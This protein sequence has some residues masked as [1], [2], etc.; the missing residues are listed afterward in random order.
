MN[1]FE[2][3]DRALRISLA[4][5]PDLAESLGRLADLRWRQGDVAGT[6][7]ALDQTHVSA[8]N[9]HHV[10]RLRARFFGQTGKLD[11]ALAN[12]DRVIALADPHWDD[13][14]TRGDFLIAH[15]RLDAADA[16]YARAGVLNPSAA[17]V[18]LHRAD[19][20]ARGARFD[21]ASDLLDRA[22]LIRPDLVA[23]YL[24]CGNAHFARQAFDRAAADY[25]RALILKP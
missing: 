18:H 14:I 2:T 24:N 12:I 5:Q 20:A 9:N 15:G 8:P 13:F 7:R 19:A 6:A 4:L 1:D 3:A 25:R 16:A 23:I 17:K 21:T 10:L 22:R 11:A